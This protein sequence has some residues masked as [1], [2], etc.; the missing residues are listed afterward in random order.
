M[1]SIPKEY[2]LLFNAIS[3]AEETLNQLRKTLIAAQQQAEDLYLSIPEDTPESACA[4]SV[5]AVLSVTAPAV[6]EQIP[7]ATAEKK[8]IAF[9]RILFI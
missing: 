4:V 5:A 1:K 6:R 3:D 8:E 2:L 7:I 9:L